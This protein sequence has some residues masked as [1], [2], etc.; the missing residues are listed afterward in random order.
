MNRP[1][2]AAAAMLRVM[3]TAPPCGSG[4]PASEAST[5]DRKVTVLPGSA[6]PATAESR[7]WSIPE[8]S[9]RTVFGAGRPAGPGRVRSAMTANAPPPGSA[10]VALK[11]PATRTVTGPIE[12]TE[13]S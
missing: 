8:P 9:T 1:N 7:A 12:A 2:A 3:M 4:E 6:R 13:N 5:A 10:G 11:V